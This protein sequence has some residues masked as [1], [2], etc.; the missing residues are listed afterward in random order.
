MR[1]GMVGAGLDRGAL[2]GY[3]VTVGIRP[4]PPITAQA[5]RTITGRRTRRRIRGEH[6][7]IAVGF[8]SGRSNG[9][10]GVAPEATG[11]RRRSRQEWNSRT[12]TANETKEFR[13]AA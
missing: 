6:A 5:S 7:N 1:P 2:V 9:T 3:S 4:H 8:L 11:K 10:Q 13:T 12:S